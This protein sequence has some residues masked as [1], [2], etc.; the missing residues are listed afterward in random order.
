MGVTWRA[1]EP[2]CARCQRIEDAL[3]R[4]NRREGQ[5]HR[6]AV[7]NGRGYGAADRGQRTED[8]GLAV[9][10]EVMS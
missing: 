2:V 7:L 10:R 3:E 8:S 5:T 1:R 9:G 4:Q 6:R